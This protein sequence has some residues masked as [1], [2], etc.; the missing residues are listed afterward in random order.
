M[1]TVEHPR[2]PARVGNSG[3]LE[4]HPDARAA[5]CIVWCAIPDAPEDGSGLQAEGVPA[6]RVD[7]DRARL[8]GIPY[9]PYHLALGDEVQIREQDGTLYC[10]DVALA[11]PEL[12]VRVFEPTTAERAAEE[13]LSEPTADE[14]FWRILHALAPHGVWFERYSASYAALSVP[15]QEWQ[16]VQPFLDLKGRV[17]GLQWELATPLRTP[18]A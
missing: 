10:V 3:E 16:Y 7:G 11:A 8:V 18:T 2:R 9:F 17:E 12:T 14:P 1:D 4:A 13:L 6:V 5:D 15:P